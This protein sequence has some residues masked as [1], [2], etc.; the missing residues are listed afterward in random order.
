LLLSY[1]PEYTVFA[2][3]VRVF[4]FQAVGKVGNLQMFDQAK[5]PGL[6]SGKNS[7]FISTVF[8]GVDI[9]E[10][11]LENRRTLRRKDGY[12]HAR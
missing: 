9:H 5:N 1:Y 10:D 8:F 12:I 4:S 3:E 11:L 2:K 7:D 6:D